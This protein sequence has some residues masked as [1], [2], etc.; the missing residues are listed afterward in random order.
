[1]D[2]VN[3]IAISLV[4]LVVFVAAIVTLLVATEAID[5]G[6]LAGRP[7]GVGWF[8]EQLYLVA[9]LGGG[10]QAVAIAV[11]VVAAILMVGFM[12]LEVVTVVRRQ[13]VVRISITGE[14]TATIEGSSV[15]LL[16]ERAAQSNRSVTS[17]KC[18]ARVRRRPVAG[19][20]ASVVISCYP[21]VAM[22]SN[23]QEIRDDLQTR[24]KASV[25][26][27]TGL[28]VL[29]VNVVRVRYNRD[30]GRRLVGS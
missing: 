29:Q 3:R 17:I 8:Y 20:P 21:I 5:A 10:S 28:T 19:G 24:I 15:E 25:E 2:L 27:L 6:F 18:R 22:G 1:M 16:A 13:T 12:S 26:Q 23:V 11:S 9:D 30:D 7:S 14:G 4:A